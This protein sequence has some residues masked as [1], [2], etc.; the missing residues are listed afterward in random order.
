VSV[1]FEFVGASRPHWLDFPPAAKPPHSSFVVADGSISFVFVGA[2][3]PPHSSFV[4]AAVSVS[5]VCVGASRF[6]WL[7]L[8]LAAKL[9]HSLP[10]AA[11]NPASRASNSQPR[12]LGEYADHPGALQLVY[13][14]FMKMG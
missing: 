5:F 1:S 2:A 12:Q 4:V 6:R 8:P 10:T 3:K 13:P 9:V 14:R 11:L 7:G